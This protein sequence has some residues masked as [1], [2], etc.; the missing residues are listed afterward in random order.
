LPVPEASMP[1]VEIC[2]H[3][4][5]ENFFL[6]G[7]TAEEVLAKKRAGYDP[8]SELARDGELQQALDLLTSGAFSRGDRELFAPLVRDLVERDPFLVLA[9][10]RAYV[11]AQERVAAAYR[12]Q[13]WWQRASILNTARAGY[14][15]SDRSIR[16]Y[17]EKIWRV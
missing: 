13:A 8:R 15:S 9:D 12:D 11:Q 5:A 3:V 1:A 16:E 2:E 7:L 14:F 4:G 17:A 6:F 10:F